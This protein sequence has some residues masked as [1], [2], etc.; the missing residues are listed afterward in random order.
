MRK[1]L[2][3]LIASDSANQRSRLARFTIKNYISKDRSEIDT[4]AV[5][6]NSTVA[7]I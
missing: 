2:N 4:V 3:K 6:S 7:T 1:N 5:Y